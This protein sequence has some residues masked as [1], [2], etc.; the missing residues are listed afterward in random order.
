MGVDQYRNSVGPFSFH[1]GNRVA[2]IFDFR[3]VDGCYFFN[4]SRLL[5]KTLFSEGALYN[6]CRFNKF[7][8]LSNHYHALCRPCLPSFR[9]NFWTCAQRS[10]RNIG[11]C[12]FVIRVSGIWTGQFD[13]TLDGNWRFTTPYRSVALCPNA[14]FCRHRGRLGEIFTQVVNFM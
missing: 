5:S 9:I 10:N 12:R 14:S 4:V 1:F 13:S 2:L 8:C 7:Y 11:I 3:R 6:L